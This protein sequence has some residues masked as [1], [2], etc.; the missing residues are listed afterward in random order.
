LSSFR[1]FCLPVTGNTNDQTYPDMNN[2]DLQDSE[3]RIQSILNQSRDVIYRY[4]LKTAKYDYIS[5]SAE[6]LVGYTI[7]ELL[8]LDNTNY[9]ELIHPEDL[10]GLKEAFISLEKNGFADVEYRQKNKTGEYLWFSNHVSLIRDNEGK[11]RYHHGNIRDITRLKEAERELNRRDQVYRELVK[12]ART[13][14]LIIDSNGKFSFCNEYGLDFFGFTEREFIGKTALETIVPA[15]ESTGKDLVKMLSSIYEKPDA[16]SININ[17]NIKKNGERVWIEWHNK[18]L[19]EESGASSGHI[20][21]G[22]DIT[23]R[24]HAE[25]ALALA[26]SE[27]ERRRLELKAILDNAPIGIWIAHDPQCR[28]ITG[29]I[30]ANER[31]MKV[32]PDTNI[33]KS[34]PAETLAVQYKVFKNGKEL[35]TE[36]LPAQVATATG[37]PVENETYELR[38]ADGRNVYLLEGAVPVFDDKGTVSGAVITGLDIT[39]QRETENNLEI[40]QEKLNLALEGGQIGLWEWDFKTNKVFWD[41]RMLRLFGVNRDAFGGNYQAFENL[42]DEEDLMHIKKALKDSIELGKPYETIYRTRG[43]NTKYI[44]SKAVLSSDNDGNPSRMSGICIDI[45]VL[46]EETERLVS[47]LNEDLLRSNKEL[48]SFAYVASHDLQEPLRMVSSFTQLLLLQYGDKLDER[49]KEYINYAVSGAQRMYDLINGLLAYSRIET[50]GKEF[51]LVDL[52]KVLDCTIKNLALNIKEKN[53]VIES[54]KLPRVSGDESQMI[55]LFQNLISNSIKFSKENPKIY[56]SSKKVRDFYH[57]SIR[58]EGMGIEQLYFERIFQIFQRLLPKDQYEGTGIGLAVCK[59]IVERH[60]GKIWV[61]SEP[62]KGST[63][64]F[65][66]PVNK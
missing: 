42:V 17:E 41:D 26:Y 9:V 46:Q 20:A 6:K 52:E 31:I 57:L 8:A 34:A 28:H 48:E 56:I 51:N 13:I 38:F 10:P 37:R 62:D 58:D 12:H 45:T 33:S 64:F 39:V 36:E 53:A 60:G 63:F 7:N 55:Q 49:A 44:Y 1:L 11:P 66:L 15:V 54:G 4:D 16:Y 2:N 35:K 43:R 29:N 50:K 22:I 19:F 3:D 25:E 18:A 59:R 27:A 21:I 61:E 23:E 14:I 47:K 40:L 5:P 65:T 24:K 32:L 30:Y